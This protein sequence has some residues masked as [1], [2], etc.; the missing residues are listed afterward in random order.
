[1]SPRLADL[2]FWISAACCVVAQ[3]ALVRSA[4]RS[5]MTGTPEPAIRMPRRSGEIAWTIVPAIALV[6]L[7]VATWRAMH[8]P[9]MPHDMPNMPVHQMI[10][11]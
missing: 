2:V 3:V 4:I 8:P 9:V 10:D 1:M 6:L 11:D 7:L 5:P